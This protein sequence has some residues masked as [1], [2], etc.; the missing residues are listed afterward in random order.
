MKKQFNKIKAVAETHLSRSSRSDTKD[1]EITKIEKQVEK[2]KDVLEKIHKK[3]IPSSGDQERDKRIKK[4]HEFKLGQALEE[5]S[6]QLP[7]D[8]VLCNILKK[9][10]ELEKEIAKNAIDTEIETDEKVAK[11]LKI[12][13]EKD[14]QDI[15]TH[16]RAVSRYL[17]ECSSIRKACDNPRNDDAKLKQ[18]KSDLEEWETKLEKE[19]DSYAA[20]MFEL[21]AKDEEIGKCIKT[22]MECQRNFYERSLK[23]IDS[24]LDEINSHIENCKKKKIF[25]VPLKDHLSSTGRE[26]SY[27]IELCCLILLERGLN[28]EGLLRVNCA[29][30]KLKRFKNAI[31]AQYAIPPLQQDYQDVHL[32]ACVLKSYLRELPEPLL[33]FAL[34]EQFLSAA[35]R[36]TIAERKSAIKNAVNQL[37]K[38]NYDNLKYLTKFL[39]HFC[40]HSDK[41][42]MTSQNIAIVMSPNILWPPDSSKDSQTFSL[43]VSSSANVNT[44]VDLLVSDWDFFF[45][46]AE[47]EFALM[48]KDKLFADEISISNINHNTNSHTMMSSSIINDSQQIGNEIQPQST[49]SQQN[50]NPTIGFQTHSRSSSHD[51]SRILIGVTDSASI[52]RS[53]SNDSLSDASPSQ[54]GSPKLLPRRKHNKASAPTPPHTVNKIPPSITSSTSTNSSLTQNGNHQ[55]SVSNTQSTQKCDGTSQTVYASEKNQVKPDK[56]PRPANQPVDSFT[57]NRAT[58]KNRSNEKIPPKPVAMPRTILNITKSTENLSIT[59]IEETAPTISQQSILR[60]KPEIREKPSIP[61]RPVTLM[62]PTSFRADNAFQSEFNRHAENLVSLNGNSS[63]TS[64]N[65]NSLESNNATTSIKK[66]SSF[67]M[68]SSGSPASSNAQNNNN[69]NANGTSVKSLNSNLANST[70]SLCSTNSLSSCPNNSGGN[71]V[72]T[73]ERA[74]FYSVDKQQVAIID[75]GTTGETTKT[76]STPSSVTSNN[77]STG[78]TSVTPKPKPT[79]LFENS[80]TFADSA[81]SSTKDFILMETGATNFISN[82]TSNNT[83]CQTTNTTNSTTTTTTPT[84]QVPISP[85]GLNQNIKRPQVP[86]PPPPTNRRK[87]DGTLGDSTHL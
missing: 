46:G 38:E 57:L 1:E 67:R 56:P 62:R 22:L 10:G 48:I 3:I 41:N 70:N 35:Q 31:D 6:I 27:V 23:Q 33:T 53:H 84:N 15:A 82:N 49:S 72:T 74:Q 73:L 40:Q 51:T 87:S 64:N 18:L 36:S 2:Y 44:I 13:L 4:V 60:E 21:I 47:V 34:Y 78:C 12:I 77:T 11:Q 5:S 71:H 8:L 85:R 75:V 26:I 81:I 69:N 16:R 63:Q 9:C 76:T 59:P 20:Q 14:I 43:Q 54:S 86:A 24:N 68:N 80:A 28:E 50:Q 19:R 55:I 39:W 83:N 37:P 42:K 79:K 17:N 52:G 66:A 61:E 30:T 32:A 7:N 45:N 25:G 65:S 58:Y 29:G